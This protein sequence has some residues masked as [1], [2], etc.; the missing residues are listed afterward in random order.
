M[1]SMELLYSTKSN[2]WA[3][4][5]TYKPMLQAMMFLNAVLALRSNLYY[6][7]FRYVLDVRATPTGR[8][9]TNSS[10]A[11]ACVLL[12]LGHPGM[13]TWFQVSNFL[14]SSICILSRQM[15]TGTDYS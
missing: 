11:T 13:E 5:K 1:I 7:L 2:T 15:A 9:M 8:C 14:F 3:Y 10:I 4:S 12:R 6:C